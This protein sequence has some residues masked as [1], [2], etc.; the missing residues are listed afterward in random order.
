MVLPYGFT[1]WF[2]LMVLPYGFTLNS[3]HYPRGKDLST[4]GFVSPRAIDNGL[5]NKYKLSL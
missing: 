1:L 4:N 2:Y 5:N 3:L